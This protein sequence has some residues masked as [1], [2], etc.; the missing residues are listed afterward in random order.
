MNVN[1]CDCRLLCTF[2]S[3]NHLFILDVRCNVSKKL[4]VVFRHPAALILVEPAF[5]HRYEVQVHRVQEKRDKHQQR[6]D[7][8]LPDEPAYHLKDY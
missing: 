7:G 3:L 6:A 8:K 4:I 1:W 2:D 5:L